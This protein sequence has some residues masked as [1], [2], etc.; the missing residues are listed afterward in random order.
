MP[1]SEL[2]AH[3]FL[4]KEKTNRLQWKLKFDVD[5]S[6][7]APLLFLCKPTCWKSCWRFPD[8]IRT[9][10]H[11]LKSVQV[12]AAHQTLNKCSQSKIW[13]TTFYFFFYVRPH[14]CHK[15]SEECQKWTTGE[16]LFLQEMPR[17]WNNI[18]DGRR[19]IWR[20]IVLEESQTTRATGRKAASFTWNHESEESDG[21]K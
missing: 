14:R 9:F 15:R 1:K 17:R 5:K 18:W 8:V 12:P 13:R 2:S 16:K 21:P 7:W 3:I 11:L 19:E 10:Q 6:V 20:E 4:L